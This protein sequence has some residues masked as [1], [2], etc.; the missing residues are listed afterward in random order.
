MC[1]FLLPLFFIL[2]SLLF[3]PD[4]FFFFWG[5]WGG[6]P[7]FLGSD[8]AH[9]HVYEE[10][11]GKV[12]AQKLENEVKLLDD[13]LFALI[14]SVCCVIISQQFPKEISLLPRPWIAMMLK[15]KIGGV[16]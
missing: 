9:G 4:P 6:D 14:R 15:N 12:W 1:V 10:S 7:V 2:V 3:S 16:C 11:V 5:G 13:G 8:C